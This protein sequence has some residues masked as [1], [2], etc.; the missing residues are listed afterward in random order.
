MTAVLPRFPRASAV[1][2]R[3]HDALR[4]SSGGGD[5]PGGGLPARAVSHGTIAAIDGDKVVVQL[6]NGSAAGY[7]VGMRDV[8][9]R[10]S[11]G[12]GVRGRV[13]ASNRD[14]DRIT[15]KVV[16]GNASRLSVGIAVEVVQAA[17]AGAEGIDGC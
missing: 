6:E 4:A 2:G 10:R 1:R 8:E 15:I 9:I 7:P 13:V 11:V 5:L 14:K 16:R 12:V 3:V 17:D